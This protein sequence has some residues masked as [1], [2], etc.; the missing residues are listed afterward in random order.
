[1]LSLLEV[2]EMKR[3]EQAFLN[4]ASYVS[5]YPASFIEQIIVEEMDH[6]HCVRIFYR[7]NRTN[8]RFIHSFNFYRHA[9]SAEA[10]RFI[11]LLSTNF[12]NVN[13]I[14]DPTI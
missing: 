4:V 5:L 6:V 2:N 11:E 1:M 8:K 14:R 3:S 9:E 13:V 10:D 7:N 12:N